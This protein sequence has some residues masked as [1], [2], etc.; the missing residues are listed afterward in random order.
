MKKAL[1]LSVLFMSTA[2]VAQ[3]P[4]S[5]TSR[6]ANARDP[7]ETICRN[8]ADTGS[9]LSR[10]RVCMTR[11][12]WETQRRETRQNLDRAQANRPM[13]GQ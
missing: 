10:S 13:S 5:T 2:A 6:Q 9:R 11:E 1:F 8:V 12:Q 4:A 3:P 7:G